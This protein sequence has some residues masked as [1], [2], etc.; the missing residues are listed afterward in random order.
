MSEIHPTDRKSITA[1]SF[2]DESFREIDSE[3]VVSEK[4]NKLVE[5]D[6]SRVY[7]LNKRQDRM[8]HV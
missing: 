8:R 5:A 4:D 7:E 1:R 2:P 3:S 6:F